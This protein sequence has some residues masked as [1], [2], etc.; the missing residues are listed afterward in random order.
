MWFQVTQ[1]DMA[2]TVAWPLD[3]NVA[4]GGGPDLCLISDDNS[5]RYQCRPPQR[6]QGPDQDLTLG[7]SLWPDISLD[8]GE[9]L[10]IH[11]TLFFTTITS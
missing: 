10:T 6:L 1:I 7:H 2:P 3:T 8:L 4:P 11:I 9:Q 5:H